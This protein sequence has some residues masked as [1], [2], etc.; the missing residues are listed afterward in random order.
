MGPIKVRDELA[1]W[2][3]QIWWAAGVLVRRIT[4]LQL[5][6]ALGEE[7]EPRFLR[8]AGAISGDPG[9]SS[10]TGFFRR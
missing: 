2:L 1:S 8:H 10:R 3:S 4:R 5:N 7:S 9:L 6:K